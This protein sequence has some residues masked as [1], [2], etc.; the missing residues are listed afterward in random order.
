VGNL[1]GVCSVVHE[2]EVD[3]FGV[4]NEESLVAGGHH[5]SGLLVGAET[6]LFGVLVSHYLTS[7]SSSPPPVVVTRLAALECI[8]YRRHDHLTLEASSDSVV[9]TLRFAP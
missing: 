6:N 7:P 9:D 4:V 3:V 1:C 5:M 8:T 2:E